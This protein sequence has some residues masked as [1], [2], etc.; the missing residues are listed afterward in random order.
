[1]QQLIDSGADV[2]VQKQ[3]SV[4]DTFVLMQQPLILDFVLLASFLASTMGRLFPSLNFSVINRLACS[5]NIP[6]WLYVMYIAL[7]Q[8]QHRR[9]FHYNYNVAILFHTRHDFVSFQ[10]LQI[11][12]YTLNG[13]VI[14]FVKNNDM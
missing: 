8:H 3:V 7:I 13:S 14:N 6:V 1:M 5:T 10:C 9:C 2:H 4:P 12:C 11:I